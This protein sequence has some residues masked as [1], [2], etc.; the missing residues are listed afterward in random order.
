[1]IRFLKTRELSIVLLMVAYILLVGAVNPDFLAGDSLSLLV[2]ASVILIVMAIGQSFVLL[3][4][5]ID[6]SVGSIMGF[7]AAICGTL[8]TSGLSPWLMVPIVLI[9]GGAI[10][11]LNGIGVSFF[12]IPSIIMTLGMLG[13]VR[14]SMLLYTE[15]M[16]IEDIPNYFK[17]LSSLKMAGITLPV[18]IA[19]VLLVATHLLLKKTKIGQYFYAV[20]DNV[21]GARLVGIPVRK[22][23]LAA[24]IVS[25]MSASI[26]GMFFV[27]NIGFVPNQTG[28]GMELQVIAAAVLGGVSL[29]GGLG[30]VLGAGV[31]AVFFTIINNSLI[32]LKIPSYYNSAISGLLLLLIVVGDSKLQKYLREKTYKQRE[33]QLMKLQSRQGGVED[34]TKT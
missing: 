31:G 11:F 19:I 26:A 8:L 28:S 33:I 20:G 10:G 6:V 7:S 30:S 4:S 1:M 24:F 18:W 9:V 27:M 14:G 21:E 2:K 13:V 16:W 22:M 15:G 32:F 17:K 29:S 12:R 25:G 34:V 5:N 23:T 3:T